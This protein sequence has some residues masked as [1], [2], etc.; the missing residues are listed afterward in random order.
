MAKETAERYSEDIN[1]LDKKARDRIIKNI[2]PHKEDI[3]SN[4][5]EAI[6]QNLSSFRIEAYEITN[7]NEGVVVKLKDTFGFIANS[8]YSYK[9]GL[10]FSRVSADKGIVVGDRVTFEKYTTSKGEAA[11]NVRKC[12]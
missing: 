2:E 1:R 10:Y 3:A 9:N 5:Y 6:Y 8:T 12:I 4:I 11:R 7:E